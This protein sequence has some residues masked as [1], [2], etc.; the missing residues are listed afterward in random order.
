MSSS[1]GLL[2]QE[3]TGDLTL[4]KT[5]TTKILDIFIFPVGFP[6]HVVA[7]LAAVLWF[8]F[9]TRFPE[10]LIKYFDQTTIKL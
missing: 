8:L 5:S 3:S 7:F 4:I 10:V 2:G 6:P 9:Q 1:D